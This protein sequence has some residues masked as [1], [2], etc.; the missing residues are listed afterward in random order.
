MAGIITRLAA[1]LPVILALGATAAV[2]QAD[3]PF[4]YVPSQKAGTTPPAETNFRILRGDVASD[5]AWPW[6]VALIR[7]PNNTLFEG[8]Y[9]GGSLVTRQWVMT[10]A[11]C[12][13][14]KQADGTLVPIAPESIKILAGTNLLM[15]NTGEL[16]DVVSVHPHPDYDPVAIDNDI[17]LIELSRPPEAGK[18]ATVRLPSGAVEEKLA[19]PGVAAIVTGW[20]RMQDGQFPVDLRQVQIS[21]LSRDECNA[22]VIEARAAEAREAFN[23]AR[24]A[25][26][27]DDGA[28]ARAW[29][30]MIESAAGP[31]SDNMVCSGTYAG[32]L[33]SCNGD[34][35]GPLV[36]QLTDGG[37]VQV[38]IVSWGF[39][40]LNDAESCNPDAR[41]SAFTRVAKFEDWIRSIVVPKRD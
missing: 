11:H 3:F 37:Y 40:S 39:T 8:Q 33:G 15:D 26:A 14:D 28:A 4:G 35:G 6:Q 34:S 23:N 21:I 22:S 7:T 5:G 25:L 36:V 27:I 29:E 24:Q 10:A 2:A 16:L 32:G 19:S 12:V 17:A 1:V 38:G 30:L 41:F 13:Y 18:I 31:I 9:C 20:G